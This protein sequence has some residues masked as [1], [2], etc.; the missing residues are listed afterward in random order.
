MTRVSDVSPFCRVVADH[1]ALPFLALALLRGHEVG[2]LLTETKERMGKLP[3]GVGI[4]GFVPAALRKEQLE[5]VREIRPP[6]AII[7]G[8]RPSQARQLEELGICT[9]LHVPSPGLLDSFLADGARKFIFEGR[10]CGGHVGPRSSFTLWQS[11]IDVLMEAELEKP[12]EVHVVFAGGIHDALSAAMVAVL[13]A[14]LVARGMKIGVLMGTA[15][16]FTTE[17]VASGAITAEFQRQALD[18]RE[19]ILLESGVGHATRCVPSPFADEFLTAKHELVR[20]GTEPDEIR[21]RLELLNIGRLRLAAKGI[22]RRPPAEPGGKG[23]LHQVDAAT[24]RDKGMFMIGQVAALRR[25]VVTMA[26]L[27]ADVSAG[28]RDCLERLA[29]HCPAAAA[30]RPRPSREDQDIAIVGIGCLFPQSRNL[31]QYWANIVAGFNA[32]REVPASRWRTED[33]YSADRTAPDKVNSKWGAFLDDVVFDPLKYVIP[34]ASVASIEPIQLLA[35]EVAWQALEDAGFH[36]QQFSGDRTAVIFG[37]SPMHD[38]GAEY[39]FR[40]MAPHI[41]PRVDWLSDEDRQRL[42]ASLGEVLPRWTEDSFA[43]YLPN[44]IA[45][46][47]S[48]RLNLRGSNFAVDAA[49]AASLAAVHAAVQ[50]LRTHGCDVAIAGAADGTNNPVAFMSFAKTHALT[51]SGQPRPFDDSADGIA[52]GEG[53]AALVLKRLCDAEREGD[54]DLRGDQGHR[55]RQRRPQPQSDRSASRGADE[56]PGTG[57][58]RRRLRSQNGFAG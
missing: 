4:L 55:H 24:Q 41:L 16:L 35:L 19:T 30:V 11:A 31:R 33:Y 38:R 1:G 28:S 3:W 47:V 46:R 51:S 8:G 53:V 20:S 25:R 27:H 6:Y 57:L 45:G 32:I 58:P 2:R 49:C 29:P 7:A 48:N 40:V 5:V 50:E 18:C 13:A 12:E 42:I 17:G 44:V 43:G 34:P 39:A 23:E 54:R 52:L 10:E 15:Y 36:D 9:Y 56:R 22:D 26:E 37:V 21:T 14:P